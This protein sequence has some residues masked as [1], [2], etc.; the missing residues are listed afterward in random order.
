MYGLGRTLLAQGEYDTAASW[1]EQ[2]L[3]QGAPDVIKSDYAE[4][5]LRAGQQDAARAM[6]TELD[7][8]Q[9]EASRA[10]MVAY[11]RH[12]LDMPPLTVTPQDAQA[13]LAYWHA[14]AG[15]FAHTPYGAALQQDIDAI[16]A[17]VLVHGG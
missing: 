12:Q 8:S 6:L 7:T 17:L 3:A 2:A 1:I 5:L 4:V 10:V 14:A 11:L 13:G 9:L 15:R 16:K